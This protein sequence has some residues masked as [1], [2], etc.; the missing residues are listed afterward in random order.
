MYYGD[1]YYPRT[2]QTSSVAQENLLRTK[3][4]AIHESLI[5][6]VKAV[7][8]DITAVRKHGFGLKLAKGGL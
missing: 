3:A 1:M 5:R 7:D 8:C 2:E 6:P 4:R